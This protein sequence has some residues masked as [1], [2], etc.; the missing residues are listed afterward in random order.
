MVSYRDEN[1][2]EVQVH[3]RQQEWFRQAL[4]V[5]AIVCI[6][7]YCIP[8]MLANIS[9][10]AATTVKPVDSVHGT[11]QGSTLQRLDILP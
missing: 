6:L 3:V 1:R 10:L 2:V 7:F 4:R 8:D 11:R 5:G 9:G